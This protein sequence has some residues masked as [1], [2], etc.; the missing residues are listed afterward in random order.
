MTVTPESLARVKAE[1]DWDRVN[2]MTDDE[3]E[4][5]IARDPDAA[6]LTDADGMAMRIQMIRKRLGLSQSQFAKEFR[7]PLA[8]LKDWEQARRQPDS[9]AWAYL[10]VIEND[11]DAV[12]R[13][14]ARATA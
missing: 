5:D 2:G 3:I 1:V 14:L 7:I 9:A 13:V 11:A 6:P 4:A 10:L 12:R 8:T